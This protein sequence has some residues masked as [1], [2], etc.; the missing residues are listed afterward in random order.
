MRWI[1]IADEGGDLLM[2]SREVSTG[3]WKY[4]YFFCRFVLTQ[5]ERSLYRYQR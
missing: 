4:F 3:V 2:C 5:K 1:G